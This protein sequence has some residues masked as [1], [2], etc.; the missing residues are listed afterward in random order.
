MEE[1][2]GT[3]EM[4]EGRRAEGEEQVGMAKEAGNSYNLDKDKFDLGSLVV[5]DI[6]RRL[7]C[8]SMAEFSPAMSQ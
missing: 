1:G 2:G 4:K 6:H 8:M 3:G 5:E 7:V